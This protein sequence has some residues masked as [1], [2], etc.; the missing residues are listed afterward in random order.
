MELYYYNACY[1][2]TKSPNIIFNSITN[3]YFYA[4]VR[5]R[6]NYHKYP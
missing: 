6:N 4:G 1:D 2:E 3:H 5:W